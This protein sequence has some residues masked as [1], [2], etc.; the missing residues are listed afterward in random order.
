MDV[1][2]VF[3]KIRW[4][5]CV[6]SE[7]LRAITA[8]FICISV[9]V[10]GLKFFFFAYVYL[11]FFSLN[12]EWFSQLHITGSIVCEYHLEFILL[13][14]LLHTYRIDLTTKET[15]CFAWFALSSLSFG[16]PSNSNVFFSLLL[17]MLPLPLPP[18]SPLLLSLLFVFAKTFHLHS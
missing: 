9:R 8:V 6:L 17:L 16:W 5:V 7:D 2:K 10:C 4:K 15:I 1:S 18:P 14:F 13:E 11:I 3:G 12:F